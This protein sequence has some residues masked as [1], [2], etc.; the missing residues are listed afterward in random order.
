[1][2]LQPGQDLDGLRVLGTLGEGATSRVYLVTDNHAGGELRAL[3][4]LSLVGS[5]HRRRLLAESEA[6]RLIRHPNVVSVHRMVEHEGMTG[7]LMEFVAGPTVHRWLQTTRP[8]LDECLAVA[9]GIL[10]GLQAIHDNELVHRD[11]KPSNMVLTTSDDGPVVPRLLDFGLVKDLKKDGGIT[12]T[13]VSMGTPAYMAPEQIRDASRVDH[14]ADLY[15]FGCALFEMIAGDRPFLRDEWWAAYRHVE[16]G[17]AVDLDRLPAGTPPH[18][19]ALIRALLQPE[20]EDRPASAA[21]ALEALLRNYPPDHPIHRGALSVDDPGGRA[22]RGLALVQ[23]D[24]LRPQDLAES[25]SRTWA[26]ART[27][28]PMRDDPQ[29]AARAPRNTIIPTEFSDLD[30]TPPPPHAR[31][32]LAVAAVGVLALASAAAAGGLL[33]AMPDATGPAEVAAV[34]AP[35]SATAGGPR[36]AWSADAAPAP[37][38][39]P[40]VAALA[41]AEP[42]PTR[43]AALPRAEATPRVA[44]PRPR[45]PA[46]SEAAPPTSAPPATVWGAIE[47]PETARPVARTAPRPTPPPQVAAAPATVAVAGDATEVR[48]SGGGGTHFQPGQPVP[49]GRYGIEARWQP[50]GDFVPSGE[51][52]LADG[53]RATISCQRAFF[54]CKR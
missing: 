15:S 47:G 29:G 45:P 25:G 52:L 49:A 20:P 28:D 11:I 30:P 8:P 34:Q 31:K 50:G 4:L 46:G 5:N 10:R 43:S 32:R 1:M 33:V 40:L 44:P 39:P 53:D 38:A 41:P 16:D 12:V 6:I 3:K 48:L 19:I 22:A 2:R 26:P 37:D 23:M 54:R 51:V 7:I 36:E 17:A 14:R 35:P 9:V 21:A 13:G 18:V 27:V 42:E 24:A